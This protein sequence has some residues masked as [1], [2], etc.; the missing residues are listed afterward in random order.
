MLVNHL[1]SSLTLRQLPECERYITRTCILS[2][3][4]HQ[5]T[6]ISCNTL[7]FASEWLSETKNRKI[8]FSHLFWL[9]SHLFCA[10]LDG[11][12]HS[13]LFIAVQKRCESSQK[14]CENRIFLKI[15]VII[16]QRK[17]VSCEGYRASSAHPWALA[18]YHQ[19]SLKSIVHNRRLHWATFSLVH[20]QNFPCSGLTLG[21]LA[22][23]LKMH[24][25]G[26]EVLCTRYWL[27]ECTLVYRDF[28]VHQWYISLVLI[29][30]NGFIFFL[31]FNQRN[32]M[33]NARS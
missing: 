30:L 27:T 11:E 16:C 2:G 15:L 20:S 6:C 31:L 10:C 19:F 1:Q 3:T 26:F 33:W 4:V 29:L 5:I 25:T 28:C 18:V 22:S 23:T 21:V 13:F 14:R 12:D 9:D 24:A 32:W 17:D 7:M 8:L